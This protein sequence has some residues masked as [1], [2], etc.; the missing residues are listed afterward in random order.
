[1][2]VN[3]DPPSDVVNSAKLE[4]NLRACDGM[5]A[6]LTHR[7]SGPSQ[8]ILYEIS[9]AM[10]AKKPLLVF[11]DDRIPDGI[12]PQRIL[13]QRFSHRT[14]FRQVREQLHAMRILK[15]YMGEP[16]PPRYQ[17]YAFQRS[18]G[19]IGLGKKSTQGRIV[20]N[21]LSNRGYRVFN[22][23]SLNTGNALS[24]NGHDEFAKL[25]LVIR[26]ADSVSRLSEYWSGATASICVPTIHITTNAGFK[27]NIAF[28]LEFQPRPAN[29]DP[30][31]PIDTVVEEELS[32]FEQ[33]FLKAQGD[34]TI[35]LYSRMQI[36]YASSNGRYEPETRNHY[37][38]VVMGDKYSVSGQT[39]AVGRNAHAHDNSF[40]Q[41]WNQASEQF[42]LPKLASE[43]RA[44]LTPL[45]EAAI[46]PDHRVAIGLV[47]AAAEASEAGNGPKAMEYLKSAGKWTFDTA[48][49]IGIGVATAAAK[50]VLGF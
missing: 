20:A 30:V 19:L 21:I 46:E 47:E 45:K 33:D 35:E 7:E 6:V 5:I 10:R 17:P 36:D 15:T 18:C 9:L 13:Q 26:N 28:P 24:F 14:F 22:L 40:Q 50:S 23:E 1:M 25:D 4:Q 32:L 38:E 39:G 12:I 48:S 3:F 34:K 42:D 44:L 49:K 41:V 31:R 2:V 37:M 29:I 8:Y 43:L 11:M 27:F 16:P